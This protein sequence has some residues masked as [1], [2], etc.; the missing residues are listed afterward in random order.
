MSTSSTHRRA[1]IATVVA[2][3]VE[4]RIAALEVVAQHADETAKAVIAATEAVATTVM[5]L[6]EEDV[7]DWV[8][9]DDRALT[10]DVAPHHHRGNGMA[11][12]TVAYHRSSSNVLSRSPVGAHHG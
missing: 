7:D 6:R 11:V 3:D 12:I 4:A 10:D 9:H 1:A 8:A 2:A 5:A